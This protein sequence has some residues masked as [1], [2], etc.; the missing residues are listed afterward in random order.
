MACPCSRGV[1]CESSTN[2]DFSMSA[3]AVFLASSILPAI[4]PSSSAQPI[5]S[6]SS[7]NSCWGTPAPVPPDR[8]FQPLPPKLGLVLRDPCD[9]KES[10]RRPL[11]ASVWYGEP[12]DPSGPRSGLVVLKFRREPPI[13]SSRDTPRTGEGGPASAP[14]E[15][16]GDSPTMME[17]EPLPAE[18]AAGDSELRRS[19]FSMSLALKDPLWRNGLGMPGSGVASSGDASSW[20]DSVKYWE[21]CLRRRKPEREFPSSLGLR[22]MTRVQSLAVTDN[23]SL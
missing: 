16:I 1:A 21:D 10:K 12:G 4:M 15:R 13:A 6:C 9:M 22:S 7:N 8:I 2:V 17:D 5:A 18:L 20:R 14:M 3:K 19:R 11:V 23:I